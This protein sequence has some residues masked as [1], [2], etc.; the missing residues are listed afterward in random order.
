MELRLGGPEDGPGI[1]AIY[2]PIVSE[3]VTSFEFEVPSAEEMGA[4]VAGKWPA[5]PWLVAED[6]GTILGYAYGG[7]FSGRA[8]YDWSAE[9]SLY[10]HPDA[11]R[12]G[13]GRR[14]Y[15]ALFAL[16]QAQGY[17]QAYAGITLPNDASVGIHEALG[18]VPVG[19]Y[20]SV[21]WKF[22]AWHDVG[23]WQR[24]LRPAGEADAPA[25]P[26]RLLDAF[27]PAEVAAALAPADADAD[28]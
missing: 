11:R 23:W 6:G 10:V 22:G 19:V 2:A 1:R 16:L 17:A 26:I 20:R 13:V 18:F 12:T 24:P 8:A 25:G 4:R 5:H 15:A 28:R 27:A 3:T 21:G 7:R 14:L 9:V